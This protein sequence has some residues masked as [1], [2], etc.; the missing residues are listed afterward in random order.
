M[1]K[2]A[3]QSGLAVVGSVVVVGASAV[4]VIVPAEELRGR[5]RLGPVPD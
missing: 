4:D 3:R 2:A 1:Q 5:G